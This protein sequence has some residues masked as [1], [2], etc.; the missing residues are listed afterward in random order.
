MPE[1][2]DIYDEYHNRTGL[3]CER[4][5][6]PEGALCMGSVICF[7][8]R[9]GEI[10]LQKRSGTRV[11]SGKWD[12]S[13]GGGAQVGETSA[14]NVKRE[15]YEELGLDINVDNTA[16]FDVI[17]NSGW[18]V[19]Y[20]IQECDKSI[21][22]KIKPNEEVSEVKFVNTTLFRRML[23]TGEF[24]PDYNPMVVQKLLSK[25]QSLEDGELK[26][27]TLLSNLIWSIGECKR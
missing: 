17:E 9:Q 6:I 4:D 23:L 21:L 5:K 14:E 15:A 8:T 1:M 18:I 24:R 16:L 2:M 12:Y 7:I 25:M 27:D 13:A 20:Y 3:T 22:E 19:N 10:L 26:R 11:H